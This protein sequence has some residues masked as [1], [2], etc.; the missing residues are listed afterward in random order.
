MLNSIITD[1]DISIV[2]NCRA[3]ELEARALWNRLS[4]IPA[5]ELE[6]DIS[7]LDSFYKHLVQSELT[8]PQTAAINREYA[9]VQ[10]RLSR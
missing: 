10:R 7:E 6:A 3:F 1:N 5:S 2:D 8:A 4:A 9:R